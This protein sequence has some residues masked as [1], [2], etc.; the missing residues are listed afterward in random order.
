MNHKLYLIGLT[1]FLLGVGIHKLSAQ[2]NSNEN[3]YDNMLISDEIKTEENAETAKISASKLLDA[4]PREIKIDSPLLI[5]HQKKLQA[6]KR[7]Q[8]RAVQN[9]TLKEKEAAPFGLIWGATYDE[10]KDE[11]V[12]LASVGQKDYV[13][14]FSATHL[15]KT[16]RAFR[17]VV[18][19]FGIENE[20]W[21]IIAY[22]NFLDDT[23]SAEKVLA[24]YNQYYR[25]LEEK[26]GNA[27]QFYTPNV[28]NVDKPLGNGKTETVQQ[29]QAIGN[30]N[31]LQELQN[32]QAF[33]YA[34]FDNSKVGAA[35]SV[36]V[37]GDGKSY[38]TVEY[39]NLTIMRAREQST[40]DAL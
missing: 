2:S 25:L 35:L 8:E 3:F 21:R 18:L 1:V 16:I 10:V 29:E 6:A 37:D 28:I 34:T 32:G 33:L 15:P 23:P 38:I 19:T 27:Q 36:N 17:E 11:G 5:E 9:K 40:M 12:S 24:V 7:A 13:N 39:K 31:F 22:G 26:Y 20:L 30:P 14:N 4:K